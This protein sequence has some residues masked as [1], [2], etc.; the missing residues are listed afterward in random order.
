MSPRL[1]SPACWALVGKGPPPDNQERLLV[2]A[3]AGEGPKDHVAHQSPELHQNGHTLSGL[4]ELSLLSSAFAD[5]TL[6]T[7]ARQCLKQ[8]PQVIT[9]WTVLIVPR[10]VRKNFLQIPGPRI[11]PSSQQLLCVWLLAR[12]H[13]AICYSFLSPTASKTAPNHSITS[14]VLCL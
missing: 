12:M 6:A 2:S 7:T 9:T 1:Q 10:G 14:A 8:C 4:F 5:E 3:S 11:T 13:H